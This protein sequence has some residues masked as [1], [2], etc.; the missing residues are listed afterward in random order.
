MNFKVEE[1]EKC[2]TVT[3]ETVRLNATISPEL[4]TIFT[5]IINDKQQRNIVLDVSKCNYCDSSGLSAILLGHRMCKNSS[6]TF[7]LSGSK[8]LVEKLIQLSKLDSILTLTPTLAEAIDIIM[9]NE[10]EKSFD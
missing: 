4:K 8:E 3:I 7:V 6:G 1:Q 5:E 9:M 10:I 2:V